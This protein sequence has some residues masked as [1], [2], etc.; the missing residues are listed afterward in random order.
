[1][2]VFQRFLTRW[3]EAGTCVCVG[4]DSDYD[5]IPRHLAGESNPIATFN[6]EIITA[7]NEHAAAYKLNFAFY[8]SAGRK[9][10]DALY[11]TIDF[12]PDSIPVI[13]DIKTGDIGNTMRHYARGF[14]QELGVDAV[15][16]NPL[17]GREVLDSFRSYESQMTFILT[18]TSN[19]G[20][21]DF[22]RRQGLYRELA[23]FVHESGTNTGAVVGATNL[24]ELA[25]MRH[26]MPETMF[27]VPGIGAQGGDLVQT[28]HQSAAKPD[29]PRLLI[30]SSRGIIFA[31]DGEDFAEAA[32][33]ET[34]R[35]AEIIRGV[36]SGTTGS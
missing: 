12:V 3:H 36:C 6:R 1:M 20:A 33:K 11:E 23:R 27:L 21:A 31:S 15:T 26:M 24:D 13:L 28:V 4:L 22:L 32:G 2:S 18:L 5:R 7:T 30:N 35:L 10:I 8:L 16:V 25:E 17:M 29:E 34:A 19:P 14:F 9:G